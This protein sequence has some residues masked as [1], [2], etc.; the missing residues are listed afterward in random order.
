MLHVMTVNSILDV[1]TA[2][3]LLQSYSLAKEF[4]AWINA[5]TMSSPPSRQKS[6]MP[7]ADLS[8]GRAINS[9]PEASA[10]QPAIDPII[11]VHMPAPKS[12]HSR[13]LTSSSH[14]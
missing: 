12:S 8:R 13:R 3:G 1:S 2:Q 7:E 6:L 11:T 14:P 10:P 5:Q 4:D 9:T